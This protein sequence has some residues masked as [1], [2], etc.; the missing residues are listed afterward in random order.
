MSGRL[1][2]FLC[3]FVL[4]S[5]SAY[6]AR[7]FGEMKVSKSVDWK[8]I[9]KK[10]GRAVKAV[11]SN[12][13]GMVYQANGISAGK[14]SAIASLVL[15]VFVSYFSIFFLSLLFTSYR[16]VSQ[17]VAYSITAGIVLVTYAL[18]RRWKGESVQI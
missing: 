7:A 14:V 1:D 5:L 9:L 12:M 6:V 8:R 11:V 15:L 2:I 17:V 16:T 10:I 4:Y 3:L 18:R 13:N